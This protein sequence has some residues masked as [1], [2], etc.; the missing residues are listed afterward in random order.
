MRAIASRFTLASVF[1]IGLAVFCLANE[2]AE[3]V[4]PKSGLRMDAEGNWKLIKAYCN[5]CHSERLLTQQQL[6]RENWSKAIKRMQAQENLWDLGDN[7][8]KVLDYLS[9]YY[10][11]S[12]KPKTQRVRR[13]QLKQIAFTSLS[14]SD[15]QSSES[16][17]ES[18]LDDEDSPDSSDTQESDRSETVEEE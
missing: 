7:E 1:F 18:G 10:G 11:V 4:D 13:A 12:S 17:D 2:E 6:N 5:V 16:E 9:T 14:Q 8:S 15:L 3:E